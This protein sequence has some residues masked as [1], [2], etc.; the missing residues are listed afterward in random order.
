MERLLNTVITVAA[1]AI[2]CMLIEYLLPEGRLK[3]TVSV[4]IG[5]VFVISLAVP[6]IS[7]SKSAVSVWDTYKGYEAQDVKT[8]D[9]NYEEFFR[10]LI[11]DIYKVP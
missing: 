11:K 6:V 3:K 7:L 10:V 4:V 1:M 8:Y 2:F 5:V 9:K